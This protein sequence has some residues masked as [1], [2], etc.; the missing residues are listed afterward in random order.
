MNNKG[1]MGPKDVSKYMVASQEAEAAKNKDYF[2]M[3]NDV[4]ARQRFFNAITTE[5][6]SDHSAIKSVKSKISSMIE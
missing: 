6:S 2:D 4:D 5:N 3:L 1:K